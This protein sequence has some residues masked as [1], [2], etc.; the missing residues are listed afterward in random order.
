MGHDES[1]TN[2]YI[3]FREDQDGI[4]EKLASFVPVNTPIHL[5]QGTIP[6]DLYERLSGAEGEHNLIILDDLRMESMNSSVV[7][8]LFISGRHKK[9]T[10]FLTTQNRFVPGAKYGRNISLNASFIVLFRSRDIGQITALSRQLFGSTRGGFLESAYS[11]A[12]KDHG[13]LLID[14]SPSQKVEEVKF[15]SDVFSSSPT[16]YIPKA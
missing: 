9:A 13:Y 16:V 1:Y 6:S 3:C 8:Q 7:N 12:I 11:Q 5:F 4:Y 15:R 10:I 14:C 2:V